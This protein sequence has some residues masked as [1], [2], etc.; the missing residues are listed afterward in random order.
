MN[1]I[2]F[3]ISTSLF[4][5]ISCDAIR[6]FFISD[7]EEVNL[8]NKFK[9]EILAD[10][11][12]YPRFQGD[13]RVVDFVDSL[14]QVIADAQKDRPKLNFTFTIL[15]DTSINAFAV[16][17]GHVFVYTGLLKNMDNTAEL[18]GVLAHEIGHITKYHGANK[19]MQGQAIDLVNQILFGEDSSSILAA[20]T[21]IVESMTFLQ[22]SQKD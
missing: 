5:I 14:G 13:L 11:K 12:N 1:P 6:P 10:T 8:G 16:P 20:V 15:E 21:K 4:L 19:L 2:K 17:G 3:I 18:A 9:K 22:L 7:Q